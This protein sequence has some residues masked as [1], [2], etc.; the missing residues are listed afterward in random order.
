MATD[1]ADVKSG[2]KIKM[3]ERRSAEKKCKAIIISAI[4]DSQL[5]LVKDCATPKRI[6]DTLKTVFERRGV[7]GQLFVRKQLLT[8]KYVEGGGVSLPEHL[9][10]FDRLIREL[11]ESGAT[12]E[13]SDAVCHLLLT[14]PS[15]FDSVVTAI[16]TIPAGVTMAFVKK[17]LL[18]VDMKQNMLTRDDDNVGVAMASRHVWGKITCFRCGRVGHKQADC[19]VSVVPK[20]SGSGKVKDLNRKTDV[21]IEEDCLSDGA[22]VCFVASKEAELEKMQWFLDSGATDHMIKDSRYFSE[23]RRLEKPVE[24]VVANGAKLKAT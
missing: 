7:A 8:L 2:K 9:L 4:A 10:Q 3:V 18:D 23:M 20:P 16:E 15:S 19:R 21:V 22:D 1:N 13:D 24:V 11:K 17:R 5:E 12:V 6:W 14:L